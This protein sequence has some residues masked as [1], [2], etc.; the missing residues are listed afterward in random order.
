MTTFWRLS[1]AHKIQPELFP[2]IWKDYPHTLSPLHLQPP[3]PLP[4]HSL[5][6]MCPVNRSLPE[7][8]GILPLNKMSLNFNKILCLE[9]FAQLMVSSF[10]SFLSQFRHHIDQLLNLKWS[11]HSY[12]LPCDLYLK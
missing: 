1:T 12:P 10:S 2:V 6:F 9:S 11:L 7:T 8:S 5:V 3:T 4:P